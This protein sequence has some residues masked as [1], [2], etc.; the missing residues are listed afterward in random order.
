[1]FLQIVLVFFN[2]KT[3]SFNLS[4][5]HE[6]LRTIWNM[7]FV[8]LSVYFQQINFLYAVLFKE[9]IQTDYLNGMRNTA[10]SM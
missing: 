1:M 6:L 3:N 10:R 9:V 2:I 5:S 7:K 8:A 4:F